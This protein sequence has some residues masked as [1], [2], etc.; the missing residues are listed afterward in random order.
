MCAYQ[1]S[2]LIKLKILTIRVATNSCKALKSFKNS[3]QE[4]LQSS[5]VLALPVIYKILWDMINEFYKFNFRLG[6]ILKYS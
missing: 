3:F 1:A 2:E 6:S 4:G 5:S